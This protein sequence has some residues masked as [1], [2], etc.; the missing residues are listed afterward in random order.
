MT[1]Q[2]MKRRRLTLRVKEKSRWI[3][4][5]IARDARRRGRR[6]PADRQ[7]VGGDR[8]AASL[9]CW[10][11]RNLWYEL[12]AIS[13]HRRQ[14]GCDEGDDRDYRR[15]AVALFRACRASDSAVRGRH[16][17]RPLKTGRVAS[18]YALAQ[19]LRI[20]RTS[21]AIAFSDRPRAA[22]IS[23]QSSPVRCHD[24]KHP[25]ARP[26]GSRSGRRESNSRTQGGNLVLCH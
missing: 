13:E 8:A 12:G 19:R 14:R 25:I 16:L 6:R 5:T 10:R 18:P 9:S 23:R 22:K 2:R 1:D 20:K 4:N 17:T 24:G 7:P 15:R 26:D 11:Q 3:T 21:V